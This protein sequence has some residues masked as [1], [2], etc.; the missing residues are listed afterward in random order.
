MFVYRTYGMFCV[1]AVP[2]IEQNGVFPVAS[3]DINTFVTTF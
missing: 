3:D 1:Y 2:Y